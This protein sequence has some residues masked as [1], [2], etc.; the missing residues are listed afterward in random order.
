ME[1]EKHPRLFSAL[2]NLTEHDKKIPTDTEL[3]EKIRELGY[4]MHYV[5]PLMKYIMKKK[6]GFFFRYKWKMVLK[7]TMWF[8]LFLTAVYYA[9]I[10]IAE[11]IFIIQE[12]TQLVAD[13]HED[14]KNLEIPDGNLLFMRT[15]SKLES[16]QNYKICNGQYWGAFQLG[17]AARKEVG[18]EGMDKETFLN[19]SIIQIWAMNKYMKKNFEYLKKTIIRYRIPVKGGILIGNHLVTQSGF[20]GASHLVG[21]GAATQWLTSKGTNVP[22]DGNGVPLTKYLEL[23]NIELQLE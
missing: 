13:I 5:W 7:K 2:F 12:R 9:W 20:L 3:D 10:K 8:I 1:R 17:D 15:I 6:I 18:L 4:Y 11:P 19:D 16:R 21:A 14:Y 22:V 23:N